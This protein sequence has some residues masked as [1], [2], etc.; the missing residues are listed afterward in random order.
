MKYKC[1]FGYRVIKADERRLK[2]LLKDLKCLQ[3]ILEELCRLRCGVD[4]VAAYTET[5]TE[6]LKNVMA[7][8]SVFFMKDSAKS[9]KYFKVVDDCFLADIEKAFAMHRYGY[10]FISC[11]ILAQDVIETVKFVLTMLPCFSPVSKYWL[12]DLML[13]ILD[14]LEKMCLYLYKNTFGVMDNV[15]MP[16]ECETSK[17]MVVSNCKVDSDFL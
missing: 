1:D 5:V 3:K 13:V 16:G 14:G 12:T 7:S 15:K 10:N 17:I 2:I 9:T 8:L 6:K 11:E 4:E